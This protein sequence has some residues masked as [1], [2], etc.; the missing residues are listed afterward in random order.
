M[1]CIKHAT[2]Y[3]CLPEWRTGR[4]ELLAL[5]SSA[6][7]VSEGEHK[8]Y[9]TSLFYLCFDPMKCVDSALRTDRWSHKQSLLWD[10][11]ALHRSCRSMCLRLCIEMRQSSV[12]CFLARW[13]SMYMKFGHAGWLGVAEYSGM[14]LIWMK[15]GTAL[16]K[17]Q[18]NR[19]KP[20]WAHSHKQSYKH[21]EKHLIVHSDI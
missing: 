15:K 19:P 16:W 14:G 12:L 13:V 6:K 11:T 1:E 9:C 10:L 5:W 18:R 7:A 21:K 4:L 17:M 8:G 3:L 2:I 20:E